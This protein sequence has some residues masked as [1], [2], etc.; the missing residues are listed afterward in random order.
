MVTLKGKGFTLRN[1]RLSDAKDI[2]KNINNKKIY[3]PTLRIPYPY[4]LKHA[5]DWLKRNMS[6]YR[7]KNKDRLHLAIVIDGEVVGSV[8]L[9][10]IEGHK[11]EIGYWLGEKFWGQGIMTQ[12]VKLLT[13]YGFENFGLKRITGHVFSSNKASARVLEKAGFKFEGKLRKHHFKD[14]K[15]IDALLYAK[16]K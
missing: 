9:I 16:V 13:K 2:Q 11:S 12:A 7:K 5:N 10:K 3:E 6:S 14:G 4:T 1:F 8:G 15:Y